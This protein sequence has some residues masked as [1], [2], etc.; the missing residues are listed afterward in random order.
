MAT[1]IESRQ[2]I[3][4]SFY[5]LLLLT[6][7]GI[8]LAV[9]R[10]A[11]GLGPTT[12]MTDDY[13]WGIWIT[14]DVFLIPVAGAAFTVSLISYFF[15]RKHCH[16]VI[17]PAVLAGFLG[18]GVVGALLFMDIG[19]WNQM[20]NVFVPNYINY[21]SFLWEI[22]LCV[23]L[24]TLLLV[25]E[26]SPIFLERFNIQTP[27]KWIN[28]S[29]YVIAGAGIILS[30]LHQSSIGSMFLLMSHK[31]HPLWWTPA[32]PLFFFIQALFSGLATT[33][34]AVNLTWRGLDLPFDRT[35][36]VR[37]SQFLR[38]FLIVY[39]ILKFVDWAWAGDLGLLFK[40]DIFGVMVWAELF[41]GVFVPLAILFSKYG[42]EPGSTSLAGGLILMG[43]LLHRLVVSGLGLAVPTSQTYVPHWMEV[44]MVI[45]FVAGAFLIYG[46]TARYFRL[47]PQE[48]N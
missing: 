9:Y 32:L 14:V 15:G 37:L 4:R 42:T 18:Y 30:S 35:L 40:F 27:I 41:I 23:T 13:P 26:V 2:R 24:Y 33:A 25:I 3:P 8:G 39:V 47:F 16:E 36:F 48:Q 34:I 22:A 46:A 29:I 20:Y 12:N 6:L 17:R 19:R 11:V 21:H 5:P 28:R 38:A 7:F 1:L 43:I 31:L 45:G 10:L 44:G